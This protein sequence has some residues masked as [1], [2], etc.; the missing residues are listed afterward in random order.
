MLDYVCRKN[1]RDTLGHCVIKKKYQPIRTKTEAMWF[2]CLLSRE[3][4]FQGFNMQ[5]AVETFFTE[6]RRNSNILWF[7]LGSNANVQTM[8]SKAAALYIYKPYINYTE[9]RFRFPHVFNHILFNFHSNR[10]V[11]CA[12]Y[13]IELSVSRPP[14]HCFSITLSS[15]HWYTDVDYLLMFTII[16]YTLSSRFFFVNAMIYCSWI[17]STGKEQETWKP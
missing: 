13:D 3:N 9:F 2:N 5:E 17:Y 6:E 7:R 12:L 15:P 14:F 4:A 10:C 8:Y 11:L 16:L 1:Q